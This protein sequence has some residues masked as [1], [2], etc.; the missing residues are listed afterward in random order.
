MN[1]KT[2]LRSTVMRH[3]ASA[4]YLEKQRAK[5]RKAREK[6]GEASVVHYFHQ[7][8]DP[9]SQLAVQKLDELRARY[10]LAFR[11]HLVSKPDDAYQGSAAHFDRWG[12]RDAASVAGDYGT[13][14]APIVEAPPPDAVGLANRLL[15]RHLDQDDFADTALSVGE[16]LWSGQ[17]ID[18]SAE[19]GA[20]ERAVA[21]G[22]AL[23]RSLG[24]YQGAMFY[25]EGEWFWGI[26]RIRLL[27]RRLIDEGFDSSDALCVPEPTPTDT[28]GLD[29]SG[30]LL[31]YFPSL[32]SPYTA[33]GHA[34]VVDLIARS[35]VA[36]RVRPVMPMLMRGI[37]APREKQRYII[38]DAARE[39]RA[40]DVPF[41]SI[42]DPFGDPVKR[43]F[44]LLPGAA[45][46][47]REL[48]FVTAYLDAAWFDGTDI[49]TESGLRIVAAKAGLDWEALTR[50]D[51]HES[52]EA[53]LE[54]N[55]NTLLEENLWGV[56]S[57]RVSG[58]GDDKAFACWGQDRIWRVENE[59]ARRA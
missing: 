54:D 35:G 33:I 45:A 49:T 32:R 5:A 34:R 52:W 28:T 16:A 44:A 36:I 58:G 39:G 19:A 18:A 38:T 27:E 17:P 15:C 30:V 40:H 53:I 10:D 25:F 26:D 41:G 57:F 42:V 23:R 24:H 51:P 55:L 47:G 7:V 6:Q 1:L 9:Y 14:F 13:R 12:R 43:A 59:I 3:L 22:N 11:P 46:L 56:P 21:E 31:E 29:A 37:P 20:G 50:A 4:G 48:D 2:R 8:D